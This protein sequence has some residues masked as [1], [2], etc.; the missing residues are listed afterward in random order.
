M[1][2]TWAFMAS[3]WGNL[4]NGVILWLCPS[5]GEPGHPTSP[6][7]LSKGEGI[8]MA[9]GCLTAVGLDQ[10][11]CFIPFNSQDSDSHAAPGWPRVL[12]TDVLIDVIA[13]NEPHTP[14][15][16]QDN[17]VQICQNLNCMEPGPLIYDSKSRWWWWWWW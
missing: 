17:A 5:Q 2:C 7:R 6:W 4:D 13:L 3:M 14:G 9:A 1:A 16:K 8:C 15:K 12:W 11:C 10:Q